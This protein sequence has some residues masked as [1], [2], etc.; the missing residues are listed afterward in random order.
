MNIRRNLLVAG[1]MLAVALSLRE[2]RAARSTCP[3]VDASFNVGDNT[4]VRSLAIDPATQACGLARRSACSK[5][6]SIPN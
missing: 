1:V 5:S 2:A 4:Y 3:R 6:I